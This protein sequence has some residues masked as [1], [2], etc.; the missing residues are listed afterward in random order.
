MINKKLSGW[1]EYKHYKCST[2]APNSINDLKY[3]IN[4][5]KNIKKIIARGHGCSNGDQ[6]VISNGIVIEMH[7]LNKIINYD[8]KKKNNRSGGWIKIIRNTFNNNER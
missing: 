3:F 1:S 6:S 7:N 8:K 2:L 4:T 5:N